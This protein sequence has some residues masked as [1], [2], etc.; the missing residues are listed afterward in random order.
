[1]I[2]LTEF[3]RANSA[4][5]D[6]LTMVAGIQDVADQFNQMGGTLRRHYGKVTTSRVPFT[7]GTWYRDANPTIHVGFGSARPTSPPPDAEAA[8][9]WSRRR[10][11]EG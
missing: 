11:D 3:E 7:F 10:R 6:E 2:H 1:M 8:G 9:P 5:L 4:G